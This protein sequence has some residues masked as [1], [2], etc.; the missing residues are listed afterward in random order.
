MTDVIQQLHSKMN[1][2][3]NGRIDMLSS[4][5]TALQ[6]GSAKPVFPSHTESAIPRNSEGSNDKG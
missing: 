4:I 3:V 2:T 6:Q 5:S 1:W